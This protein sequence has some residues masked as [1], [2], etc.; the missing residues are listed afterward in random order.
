MIIPN[1]PFYI[2]AMDVPSNPAGIPNSLD[3][4]VECDIQTGLIRQKTNSTTLKILNR[5][6]ELGNSLGNPL[7]EEPLAKPYSD[8]FLTFIGT[9]FQNGVHKLR[10]LDVG[11]GFGYL[12]EQLRKAGFSAIGLEPGAQ[13]SNREVQYDVEIVQDFFP[14]PR[15]DGKF[16]LIC[17]Y[18]VLEHIGNPQQ[19]LRDILLQL[20]E[21]G[22][23]VIAVP[24]CSE[25]ISLGDPSILLHE[26]ISYF[27]EWSLKA[28]CQQLDVDF[29]IAASNY[30]R[31]L[32]LTI[33]KTKARPLPL[34][35]PNTEQSY[36]YLMKVQRNIVRVRDTL[37]EMS[38]VGTLGIFCPA[39]AL[40]Y[41]TALSE[42]RLFDDAVDQHGKF[43]PPFTSPI[44]S[45]SNLLDQ[46]V[47][48]LVVMS[49][50]FGNGIKESLRSS[51]YDGTILLI[52]D[53]LV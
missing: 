44:E 4:Y 19:F 17:A 22:I 3:F 12:T 35:A 11:A 39:R 23:A 15:V 31:S 1:V 34:V 52:T 27:D 36:A 10:A 26:H 48:Q 50:T 47:D 13:Y 45:R 7:S 25:E 5:V 14:S 9:K 28:L 41:I 51:G 37:H 42:M 40:H 32:Y 21:Y 18:M 8:D 43:I 16:D 53:L 30:G 24:N 20:T 49:R 6:Y 38:K 46:P 2:G 29:E 33:Q